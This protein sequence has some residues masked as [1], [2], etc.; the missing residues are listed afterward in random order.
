M[1]LATSTTI[2][3]TDLLSWLSQYGYFVLLPLFIIEGPVVGVVSGILISIGGL[4]FLPVYLLYI[5]GTLI[6][7]SFLYYVS[8][9]NNDRL[10]NLPVLNGLLT[11]VHAIVDDADRDWRESFRDNYAWLIVFTRLAPINLISQFVVI[12]AGMLGIS[13]RKFYPPILLA[14]PIWS[15]AIIAVGYYFG[16]IFTDPHNLFT[17]LTILF[18]VL[19]AIFLL[20]RRYLHP[21]LHQGIL[22]RFFSDR[23]ADQ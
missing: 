16:D 19:I 5:C 8:R 13:P 15:G 1:E 4:Q 10:E 17:E 7:D 14:Q 2:L 6:S 20:Y 22:S 12:I 23:N 9:T 11:R 18:V 3:G 21:Y